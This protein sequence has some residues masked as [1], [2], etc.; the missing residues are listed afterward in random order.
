[1]T[2]SCERIAAGGFAVLA[3]AGVAVFSVAVTRGMALRAWEAF[4]VNLLFWLGVAQGGVVVSASL[5]LTQARWGGASVYR[6]AE[7]FAGF[8]PLGF[9][10]FWLLFAGHQLIFP[11]VLHPL[12]Q[13]AA[14]LNA[15][16][17][18][19]RDGGGLL[20]L[21]ALS[22]WF[23]RSSRRA[24]VVRWAESAADIELPPA[25]IRRL[26]PTVI[27][28]YAIIYSLIAFDLVMSLSPIW[29]STLFGA[30]FFAGAYWSALAAMGVLACVGWRPLPR[31]A[32]AEHSASLHDI[33]KMV[34]AFSIF[35]AYLLWSQYLPIWYADIPEETFF[36]VRRIHSLPWGVLGWLVLGLVWVV[37]FLV[38]LGRAAKRA[39]RIL[40]AVCGL[41]LIGMWIERYV[42]V[43]PS[44]S[45]TTIPFGWLEALVTAGFLGTFGLCTLPGLRRVAATVEAGR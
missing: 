28:V 16:F 14:W 43:T 13:K 5:Y 15:P 7:S 30:Y 21:T 41:G 12:P 42:L 33:G 35:W 3:I 40:G 27:I 39:P 6:L 38:L 4:L 2:R 45:P 37:P 34:F 1:M 10:L 11:W 24:D 29:Y 19:G 20:V 32:S 22:L 18:F 9:L 26:A 8:L 31:G 44:L 17:L 23:V 36:L 25:V